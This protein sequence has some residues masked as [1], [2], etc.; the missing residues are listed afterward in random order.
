MIIGL[1]G[2]MGSGKDLFFK[3]LSELQPQHKWQN[4]KFAGKLKE[5]ASLISGASIQM[6]EDPEFKKTNMGDDWG[7]TYREFLQRL[8]T[9]SFRNSVHPDIWVNALMSEYRISIEKWNE[10]CC[11]TYSDFPNWTITDIRFPNEAEAIRKR[12]YPLVRI[13]RNVDDRSGHTS[14]RALDEYGRW[15]FIINNNS[16][17]DYLRAEVAQI[18]ERIDPFVKPDYSLIRP[19]VV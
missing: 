6:W 10:D 3:L 14:E 18:A 5:V 1:S 4:K 17:V 7:M 13:N 12:G 15:D 11:A 2:K 8:G 16:D 19:A 9:D